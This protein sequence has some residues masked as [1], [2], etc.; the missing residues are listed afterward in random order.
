MERFSREIKV[1]ASLQERQRVPVVCAG[2]TPEG[3]PS[4]TMPVVRGESLRERMQRGRIPIPECVGILRDVARAL[5]Y[6]HR[7]SVI[8]CDIKPENVLLSFGT[9][10]VTDFG[11]AKALSAA[12]RPSFGGAHTRSGTSLGPPA[13]M[14]PDQAA[15]READARTDLYAWGGMAYGMVSGSPPFPGNGN[16]PR[17][18][19]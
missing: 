5:A 15:R 19:A 18:L 16:C 11:I 12:R 3:L 17:H 4:H 14:S 8:H 6:A 1:V 10:M 2:M 13:Y 7:Q 9:A